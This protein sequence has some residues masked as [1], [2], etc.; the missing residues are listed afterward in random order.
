MKS[1]CYQNQALSVPVPSNN[2]LYYQSYNSS[3]AEIFVDLNGERGPNIL[4]RDVFKFYLMTDGIVPAGGSKEIV[5]TETFENQCLGKNVY[6]TGGA[7]CTAWVIYNENMDYLHCDDLS[8]TG[9]SRC[10]K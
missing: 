9:K 1:F 2:N 7:H 5:W 10:K 3:C 4:D 6:V 8:W